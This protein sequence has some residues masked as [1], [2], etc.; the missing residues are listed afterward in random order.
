MS[1]ALV[2]LGVGVERRTIGSLG[3]AARP[4]NSLP[5]QAGRS[6]ARRLEGEPQAARVVSSGAAKTARSTG[7]STVSI[8]P[9]PAACGPQILTDLAPTTKVFKFNRPCFSF[10]RLRC[11]SG[12]AELMFK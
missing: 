6:T 2:H 9:S 12:R 10:E 3:R 4:F 1:G 11:S 8:S 5:I 7:G